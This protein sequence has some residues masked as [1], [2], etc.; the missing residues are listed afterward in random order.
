MTKSRQ[1]RLAFTNNTK[2]TFTPRGLDAVG[3]EKGFIRVKGKVVTGWIGRGSGAF[4]AGGKNAHLAEAL[5]SA[6]AEA[7][8]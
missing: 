2:V 8:A 4:F 6:A 5:M 3:D 7:V 1:V